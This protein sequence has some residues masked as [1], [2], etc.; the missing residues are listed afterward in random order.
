VV[1]SEGLLERRA[2]LAV[3]KTGFFSNKEVF[4]TKLILANGQK[5]VKRRIPEQA[6]TPS[7]Y[8]IA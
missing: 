8:P 4:Q 5:L 7:F 6:S 2:H 1:Q 3:S